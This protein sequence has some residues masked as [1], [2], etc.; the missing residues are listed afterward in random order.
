LT[1]NTSQ[2]SPLKR[3]LVT[4][5]VTRAYARISV[6]AV[7]IAVPGCIPN[8]DDL[9]YGRTKCNGR[10][11]SNVAG[12]GGLGVPLTG[13]DATGGTASGAGG[14]ETGGNA[15]GGNATGGSPTGGRGG[16]T[17]QTSHATGGRPSF[18]DPSC[19]GSAEFAD[20]GAQGVRL[21][22][23]AT[24]DSEEN[25]GPGKIHPANLATDCDTSTRWCVADQNPGHYWTLDLGASH[26]LFRFEIMWEYPFQALGGIYDYT[27]SI[28]DDDATYSIVI[29]QSAN[30]ETTQT[31]GVDFPSGTSARYV[32][33]TVVG[34]PA[35]TAAGTTWASA[36]EIRVLGQ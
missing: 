18:N 7:L 20:S 23:T 10:A 22:G 24:A 31:Q 34:L 35:P 30:T 3:E 16:S 19:M 32:R 21:F 14:N 15:T 13:G 2:G 25:N 17:S 36:Y 28:S 11:C 5:K 9:V 33:L 8:D 29:D 4:A 6:I 12:S 27:V 26:A 1:T